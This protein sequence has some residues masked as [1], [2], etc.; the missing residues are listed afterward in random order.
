MSCEGPSALWNLYR[1]CWFLPSE[2]V[3]LGTN[4]QPCNTTHL[5]QFKRIT[6]PHWLKGRWCVRAWTFAGSCIWRRS[7]EATR[8]QHSTAH[9]RESWPV[10]ELISPLHGCIDIR[11]KRKISYQ[12]KRT[13]TIQFFPLSRW[14]RKGN[15]IITNLFSVL[16][17]QRVYK[18]VE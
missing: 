7:S 16:G 14:M 5:R 10:Y 11:E 4:R 13:Q 1:K 9:E 6:T 8:I 12:K 2:I 3:L 17:E 15:D 18:Q